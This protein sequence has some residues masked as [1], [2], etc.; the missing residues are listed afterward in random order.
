MDLR[1][2]SC[3][4]AGHTVVGLYFGFRINGIDVFEGRFRTLC[5]LD[6]VDRRITNG[7]SFSLAGSL[8]SNLAWAATTLAVVMMTKR[9]SPNVE[10]DQS[11]LISRRLLK[12]W[13]RTENAFAS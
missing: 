8:E 9:K 4:E 12:S 13:S 6:A 5:D 1:H 3:H 7:S 10:E 11:K 2:P